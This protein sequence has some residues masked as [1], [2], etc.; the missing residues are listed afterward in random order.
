MSPQELQRQLDRT[1]TA[2][3]LGNNAAFLG[4]LLTSLDFFWDEN[5][6]TACTDGVEFRWNPKW[7]MALPEATRK[8]VLI[9]ELWH[10]GRLHMHRRGA[11][12]P[13]IW[14]YAC[15]IRINNDLET[16]KY[17]FD[18]A[19]N[20]WKDKSFGDMPE[21]DIY[22][23]LIKKAPPNSSPWTLN[24]KDPGDFGPPG[25]N[26]A[27]GDP[28][29]AA[30]AAQVLNNVVRAVQAATIAG[31]AGNLPGAINKIIKAHL[32]RVVPWE[33][34]LYRWMSDQ[35]ESDYTWARPNRRFQD[36]YLPS[37]FID[38]GRLEQLNY[39]LDVSGSI[40]NRDV[41]R[42]NSE[43]KYVKETYQPAKMR[44]VQFDTQIQGVRD[45]EEDDDFSYLEVKRGG[46]TCLRCVREHINN[47][48]PTAAIIFSDLDVAPML[49]PDMQIP[50]LWVYI[51]KRGQIPNYGTVINIP[52]GI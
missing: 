39:Y 7:F 12:D 38:G 52:E 10:I 45:I 46:G 13:K 37:Q 31:Q 22:D 1:K 18:G 50:I 48:Q 33:Q 5:I 49:P 41:L 11:R 51:G 6:P 35:L 17:S 9:H 19:E 30:K 15:D 26:D 8:T 36:I 34:H 25:Q 3:F 32:T 44:L 20:C 47:D 23:I 21:E 27:P 16:D 4:S 2:A 40:S 29:S 43:V 24:G 42:F 14:N 28:S